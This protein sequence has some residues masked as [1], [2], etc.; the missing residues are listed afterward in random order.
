MSVFWLCRISLSIQLVLLVAARVEAQ[1]APRPLVS[2]VAPESPPPGFDAERLV[3]RIRVYLGNVRAGPGGVRVELAPPGAAPRGDGESPTFTVHLRWQ[4]AK[5][6]P[7]EAVVVEGSAVQHAQQLKIGFA[8]S[9]PEFERLL[10]LK[11]RSVL[12]LALAEPGRELELT[13]ERADRSGPN[14]R[15]RRAPRFL[16]EAGGGA[17]MNDA[18]RDP[19]ATGA[20]RVGMEFDAWAFGIASGVTLHPERRVSDTTARVLELSWALS[21]RY[22]FIDAGSSRAVLE[23]GAELGVLSARVTA[24]RFGEERVAYAL[25]P[26]ASA[27]LLGGYRLAGD[28]SAVVLWGPVLDLLLTRSEVRAESGEIYDSGRLRYGAALKLRFAL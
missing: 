27:L 4:T 28:G 19:R 9:W 10:A 12:R 22:D 11:L 20:A 1:P 14:Q 16:L 6:T 25:S 8:Q 23:L 17:V 5:M 21:A 26:M 7:F 2:I 18:S 24:D 3:E 15:T 13:P